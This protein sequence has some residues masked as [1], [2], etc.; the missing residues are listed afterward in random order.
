MKILEF[1]VGSFDNPISPKL[2]RKYY[3]GFRCKRN[4]YKARTNNCGHPVKHRK[5]HKHTNMPY[6]IDRN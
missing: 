2:K 4:N 5:Q 3:V 6:R 1:S